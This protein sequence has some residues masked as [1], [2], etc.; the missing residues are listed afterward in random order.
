MGR[1]RHSRVE[2]QRSKVREGF[3]VKYIRNGIHKTL[4]QLQQ[5]Q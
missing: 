5:R 1:G 3:Q 2:L 4:W